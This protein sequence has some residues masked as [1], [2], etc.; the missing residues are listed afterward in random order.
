MQRR[1]GIIGL[2]TVWLLV[3]GLFCAHGEELCM[4]GTLLFR[5]DFGGNSPDDPEYSMSGVPG[6]SNYYRN[7]GNTLGSGNYTI[8]KEGW[9]NNYQWHRQDDHTYPNDKSRGYLLE[10]DGTGGDAPFYSKTIDGLCPGTR[11]AFSAYVVNVH[12]AGQIRWFEE[13]GRSYTYPRLRFVLKDPQT[14]GELASRSTGNILP[15]PRYYTDEAWHEAMESKL[16]AEWQLVGTTFTV[17]R[18]VESVQMFIYN[19]AEGGSGNGNDFAIDDIEIRFCYPEGEVAG[20][21][22]VCLGSPAHLEAQWEATGD[23]VAPFEFRWLF[24]ADSMT[25]TEVSG[26]T[27]YRLDIPAV[28]LSDSGWY[29]AAMAEEGSIDRPNCRTVT[30]PF[31]LT[32]VECGKAIR[33]YA[34]TT[35]CDTLLPY[36]WHGHEWTEGQVLTDTIRDQADEDSVY[37]RLS[38]RTK[39][40]CPEVHYASCERLDI[41]DTLMPY[42]WTFGDT[43]LL[44][45]DIRET[46]RI[47]KRHPRWDCTDSVYTFRIDTV[48]CEKLWHVI[49]NKYNRLLACDQVRLRQYFPGRTVTGYQWYKDGAAIPGAEGDDYS[50]QNELRGV[51][52]LRI[53]L[54]GG[55]TAWSNIIEI[56]TP[57]EVQSSRLRIYDSRGWLVYSAEREDEEPAVPVLPGGIYL[58]RRDYGGE[59]WTR[60][61]LIP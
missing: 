45:T 39:Q 53:L 7:S 1:T 12:Y 31:L 35:V 40:C 54:D 34:D 58:I 18:G 4:D 14:G 10:V 27:D 32:T 2:V 44:F 43:A 3:T 57:A 15:D 42:T 6:M 13:N 19:D 49:V 36:T 24:S 25:W 51:Y 16:S 41:C 17:P 33:L 38:L 9:N 59:G 30:K 48:H 22:S 37:I 23:L 47:E 8:R 52:Q 5:E 28:Q 61:L 60:K 20:R 55:Q 26:A 11:L 50:E 46:H 29:K 21:D 56:N